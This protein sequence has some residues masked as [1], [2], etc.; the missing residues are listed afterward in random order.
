MFSN[1]N[2]MREKIKNAGK[3]NIIDEIKA[4]FYTK[5]SDT[6]MTHFM[7]SKAIAIMSTERRKRQ[8]Y[9]SEFNDSSKAR[10]MKLNCH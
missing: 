2:D 1:E 5:K 3:G 10:E 8:A 4:K 6:L 7:A 9:T